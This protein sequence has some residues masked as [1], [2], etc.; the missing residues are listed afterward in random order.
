MRQGC[1]LSPTLFNE[2]EGWEDIITEWTGKTLGDNLRW[3]V[4][5]KNGESWL[6][7]AMESLWS[8][9]PR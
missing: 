5:E 8:Y 7:G 3:A 4:T 6:P 1:L 9:L 2:R